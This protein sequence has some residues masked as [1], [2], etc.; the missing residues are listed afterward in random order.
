MTSAEL[1]EQTKD[2][3]REL[4]FFYNYDESNSC[5]RLIGSRQGLLKFCDILN[6]YASDKRNAPLSEHEHY[7]PYWYLKLTTWEKPQITPDAIYG[8]LEDFRRLSKLTKQ[9][10]ENAV[11]GDK[12]LIDVE[13]SPENE[14]KILFEIEADDFDAAKADTLL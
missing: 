6:E 13:Y 10:L 2:E 8:T 14:A 9:K 3:W 4:G 1:N 5:W 11:V 12:V 7:G